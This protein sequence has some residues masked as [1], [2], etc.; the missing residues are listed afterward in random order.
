MEGWQPVSMGSGSRKALGPDTPHPQIHIPTIPWPLPSSQTPVYPLWRGISPWCGA[1]QP[2]LSGCSCCRCDFMVPELGHRAVNGDVGHGQGAVPRQLLGGGWSPRRFSLF[3][4]R[5]Q[6]QC[7][8]GWVLFQASPLAR[9]TT[10]G[11]GSGNRAHQQEL[12]WDP[13]RDFHAR[14]GDTDKTTCNTHLESPKENQSVSKHQAWEH[15]QHVTD[16]TWR[17]GSE[18]KWCSWAHGQR[19]WGKPIT[20]MKA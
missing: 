15:P 6:E 20:E 10:H 13:A 18:L 2:F 5:E 19:Q 7:W 8:A 4:I 14:D 9:C 16:E 17:F 11:Q 1:E 12:L 3:A